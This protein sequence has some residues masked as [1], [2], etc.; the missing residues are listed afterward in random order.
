MSQ[1]RI[2]LEGEGNAWFD[3]NKTSLMAP[4]RFDWPLTLLDWLDVADQPRNAVEL[5]CANGWRLAALRKRI[6]GRLIGVDA[7]SEAI[8]DGRIRYPALDLRQ[9]L[10]SNLP[11]DE[12]FDLVI[13]N[14]VL[15][16]VDR[17]SLSRAVAEIDRVV[18]D[19]GLLILGDFL[20]DRPTRRQYHHRPSKDV[21]T[22]KQDYAAIF[23]AFVT[24]RSIAR[25]AFDHDAHAPKISQCGGG[26]R[27]ICAVLKKSL[28]GFYA[29]EA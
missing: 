24:Y 9:G 2:F 3:R 5:G 10:L 7:S 28:Q 27:A 19:G 12:T 14:F 21:F 22:Y 6:P 26:A 17:S 15:H 23:E 25:I 8:A 20:P 1:D 16:W 11:L 13:V 29:D 18:A 4:N